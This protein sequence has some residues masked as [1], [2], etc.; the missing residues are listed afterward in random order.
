M[1]NAASS[2]SA[3]L[4]SVTEVGVVQDLETLGNVRYGDKLY[5]AEGKL[6]ISPSSFWGGDNGTT[7]Y[8]HLGFVH[9]FGQFP[10][11]SQSFSPA[12]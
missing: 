3:S 7:V 10:L 11:G 2:H 5:V 12:Q 9:L 1:V 4:T 6:K 8:K